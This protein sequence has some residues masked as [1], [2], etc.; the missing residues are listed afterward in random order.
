MRKLLGLAQGKNKPKPATP[1]TSILAP[2]D[3]DIRKSVEDCA[4][5]RAPAVLDRLREQGYQGGITVLRTRLRQLRPRPR[6]EAFLTRS[7][8]PGRLLQVDWGDFGYAIP[9]CARRVSA[10]VAALAY[11]RML[12]VIFTLSQKMGCFLR[13]MDA[14]LRFFGG[15]TQVD[16]FDNMSTVQTGLYVGVV[17][18]LLHLGGV[19][20][21]GSHAHHE[22]LP[23]IAA[24][25]MASA[26]GNAAGS[27][28]TPA[29]W[30]LSILIFAPSGWL[31]RRLETRLDLRARKYVGRRWPACCA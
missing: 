11:S 30:S 8:G 13:C 15:R 9:G 26:M 19:S 23:A 5:I 18:E 21:G 20:L 10:F 2:Y 27:D 1:T 31:G 3:A 4:D 16:V 29:M 14:A 12:F 25:A 28:G 6:Q 7:Y 17:F 22:T 24:A